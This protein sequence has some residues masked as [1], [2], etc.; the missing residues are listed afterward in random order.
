MD[1][2]TPIGPIG[3][4]ALFGVVIAGFVAGIWL[5]LHRER[6][7]RLVIRDG[8][9]VDGVVVRQSREGHANPYWIRYRYRDSKGRQH[10]HKIQVTRAF[11]L[12]HPEGGRI[13]LLYSRSRPSVSGARYQVE[14]MREA[15]AK[16][17]R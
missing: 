9:S 14:Q 13:A 2:G 4:Y 5:V 10:E 11:W 6:Q 12:A 16:R 15:L 7:L 3:S 8:V 17:R 1:A